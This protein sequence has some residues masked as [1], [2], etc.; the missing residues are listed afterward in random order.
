MSLN[1]LSK[2]SPIARQLSRKLRSNPTIAENKLW[3][4]ISYRKLKGHRFLR[5]HQ[6]FY[7]LGGKESFF[8]PDF[9]CHE[10][11]LAIELDGQYH[12]YRLVL[13]KSRTAILNLLG[14][15]VVRFTND[16]VL[17]D[18][19]GVLGRIEIELNQRYY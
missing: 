7:D 9:Y 19:S 8:I 10:C 12:I 2:L 14:I 11:R 1:S 13:D 3:Q 15:R 6:L 4:Y 5:Q 18:I 16:E 17:N